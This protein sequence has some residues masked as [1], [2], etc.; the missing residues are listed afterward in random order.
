VLNNT[1]L[2]GSP[3]MLSG[4]IAS[5]QKDKQGYVWLATTNGLYRINIHKK[6][7]IKFNRTDG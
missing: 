3:D 6:I 2:I 5:M 1:R 4:F 7:F